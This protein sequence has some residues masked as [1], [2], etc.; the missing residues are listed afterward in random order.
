MGVQHAF[1][2]FNSPLACVC[3]NGPPTP[4][5]FFQTLDYNSE[6]TFF[7]AFASNHA[8]Q[9]ASYAGPLLAWAGSAAKQAQ[10]QAALAN[11]SCPPS[12]LHFACHLAPWGMQSID[13]TI[14]VRPLLGQS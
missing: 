3:L 5:P 13:E 4:T 8:P 7:A 2:S 10:L 11:V 9:V 12:A 14:Y 1:A 6:S